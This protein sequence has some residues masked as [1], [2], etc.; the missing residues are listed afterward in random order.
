MLNINL[1]RKKAAPPPAQRMATRV[2]AN[3]TASYPDYQSLMNINRYCNTDDIYSVVRYLATTAA[4]VPLLAY[5]VN[6]EET[7]EELIKKPSINLSKFEFFENVYTNLFLNG[8][9][10][11]VKETGELSGSILTLTSLPPVEMVVNHSRLG[12]VGYTH[13]TSG[14][15]KVEYLEDEVIHIK[16][17]NPFNDYRGLS[18]IQALM[19]TLNLMDAQN[20]VKTAQMQNGGL[21]TIVFEKTYTDDG[22]VI[23][24]SRKSNF[25]RF[26]S[27]PTNKG[28]PYFAQGEMG[29]IPVGSNL[30]DLKVIESEKISFKKICNAYGTS[31]IL[32]NSDS[33]STESN[34]KEMIRRTYTSSVLPNVRRVCD[35]LNL[36]LFNDITIKEDISEIPELQQD[37]AGMIAALATA[38]WLTPNQKLE[39]M[40][41]GK[42][43]NPL[44][45]SYFI[46]NGVRPID[47]LEVPNA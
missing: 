21:D 14:A 30:A 24:E 5:D 9:A 39:A 37:M 12:V 15:T 46:P 25:M 19:R 31:D 6:G 27:N 7:D 32:F 13:F 43:D 26:I 44:F 35:A 38:Y 45:D 11:I 36:H 1:F 20:N 41:Y 18:P 2:T 42:S 47:D 3:T 28:V 23:S 33:G 16:Y 29:S 10:F 40:K 8:E 22:K 4:L 17:F 34:V